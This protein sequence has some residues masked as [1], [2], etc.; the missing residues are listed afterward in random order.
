MLQ[1]SLVTRRC[2]LQIPIEPE[3][4]AIGTRAYRRSCS[5]LENRIYT[6]RAGANE[7]TLVMPHLGACKTSFFAQDRNATLRNIPVLDTP[8]PLS[9]QP[10]LLMRKCVRGG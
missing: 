9:P 10:I 3:Q 6:I 2:A 8:A 7:A 5:L 4:P 1:D